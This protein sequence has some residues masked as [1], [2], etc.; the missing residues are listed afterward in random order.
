M[1]AGP[2]RLE[3]ADT[4]LASFHFPSLGISTLGRSGGGTSGGAAMADWEL[5]LDYDFF[6]KTIGLRLGHRQ[7]TFSLR[8]DSLNP[9]QARALMLG[10]ELR[11]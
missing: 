1:P 5:G 2:V 3:L 4:V 8:T 7:G 11:V 6:F 10:F 9:G